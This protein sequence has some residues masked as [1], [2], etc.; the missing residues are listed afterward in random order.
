MMF[1]LYRRLLSRW[2]GL[3]DGLFDRR[4]GSKRQ[5]IRQTLGGLEK[6]GLCLDHWHV[7]EFHYFQ[8]MWTT[9]PNQRDRAST[10]DPFSR[11]SLDRDQCLAA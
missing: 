5:K 6:T 3:H 2:W 9:A 7:I 10:I 1:S 8:Q 4:A 11:Y